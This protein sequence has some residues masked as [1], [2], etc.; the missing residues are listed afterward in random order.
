MWTQEA[1]RDSMKQMA[2]KKNWIESSE[3]PSFRV[4]WWVLSKYGEE[5]EKQTNQW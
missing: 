1:K 2:K 3:S 5:E 4:Q